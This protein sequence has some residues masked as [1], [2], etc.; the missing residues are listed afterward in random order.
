[1]RPSSVQR[2]SGCRAAPGPPPQRRPLVV[3]GYALWLNAR[4]DQVQPALPE[5]HTRRV[6]GADR[7]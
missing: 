7:G 3:A 5:H 2:I 1:M 6:L 4:S